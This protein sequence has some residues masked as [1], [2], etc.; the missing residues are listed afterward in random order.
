MLIIGRNPILETLKHDPKSIKRITIL[1]GTADKK[2]S[3]IFRKARKNNIVI[4][5]RDRKEFDKLFL[6]KDKSEGISQGILADVKDFLYSG[7]DETISKKREQSSSIVL[8]LDE[9]QDPHNLGAIIRTAAAT[10]VDA[11]IIPEKNSVKVN[12]TVI[13]A[14]SGATNFIDIILI[15]STNDAIKSLREKGYKILGTSLNSS[16]T[17]YDYNFEGHICL[18]LG[19]EGI[20]IR[21]SIMR[22]CDDLIKIPIIGKIESLNVSVAAG[23]ILYE[24]LRQ[25]ILKENITYR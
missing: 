21:K 14:S 23:V 16:I 2:I 12:H 5:H 3:D 17:H 10:A 24:I 4:E 19:S 11:I 22:F 1:T 25:K 20:G 7:F 9:I 18:I 8:I 6:K 13:K 15:K